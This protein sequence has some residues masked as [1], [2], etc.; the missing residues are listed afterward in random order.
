MWPAFSGESSGL[1]AGRRGRFVHTLAQ[2]WKR[3]R[4]K[5]RAKLRESVS[6]VGVAAL[7][8][9]WGAA[10]APPHELFQTLNS[11]IKGKAHQQS[12]R[13]VAHT[14][15][16]P[17]AAINI[18]ISTQTQIQFRGQVRS[19]YEEGESVKTCIKSRNSIERSSWTAVTRTN[20]WYLKI[21][22]PSS[23]GFWL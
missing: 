3:K 10:R 14:S 2:H 8:H 17:C 23:D 5:S 16:S 20:W 9:V 12:V 21:W 19:G 15:I 22:S 1:H 6:Y 11:G 7:V 18:M 4:L 13:K